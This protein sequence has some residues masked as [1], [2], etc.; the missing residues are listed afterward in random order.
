MGKEESKKKMVE[1]PSPSSATTAIPAEI[2]R[3]NDSKALVVAEVITPSDGMLEKDVILSRLET[4]KRMALI[5]AWEE[6]EKTKAENRAYR[7]KSAIGSWENSKKASMEARIKKIEENF[8]KKKAE[9]GEQMKNKIAMIHKE[10]EEKRAVIELQCA[11]DLLRTEEI[12]S[13]YRAIGFVP[14]KIFSC[15]GVFESYQIRR[16]ENS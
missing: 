15:F 4:E 9:Y 16:M 1:S 6:S 3:T 13:K 8:E 10:A 12:A 5:K 11:E 14:K 7:K 2:K